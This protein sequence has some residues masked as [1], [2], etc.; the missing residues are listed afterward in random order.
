MTTR[1]LQRPQG[2]IAYEVFDGPSADCPIAICTPGM[3]DIRQEYRFLV[4]LLQKSCTVVTMDLRG[5]GESSATFDEVT[6]DSVAQDMVALIDE[7]QPSS[8]VVLIGDSAASAS[9]V[10]AATERPEKVKV[11]VL[12]GPFCRDHPMNV[13]LKGFIKLMLTNTF[14]G[15]PFWGSFYKSLYPSP[16]ADLNE[17][18]VKLKANLKEPGRLVSLGKFLFATKKPCTD[19]MK[20]VK[21]KVLVVMGTKD[22]D[23]ANPQDEAEWIVNNLPEASKKE[24]FMVQGAGHYPH[25]EFPEAVNTRIVEMLE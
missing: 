24:I 4:P 20:D 18:L 1:F 8:S 14:L 21:C 3:G 5:H 11:I 2:Q 7:L 22:P 9:A 15:V 25:A 13:F 6:S 12:C 17:Y 16:P 10:Y 23:F 19:R